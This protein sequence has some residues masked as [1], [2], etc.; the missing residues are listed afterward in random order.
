TRSPPPGEHARTGAGSP[1]GRGHGPSGRECDVMRGLAAHV[2]AMIMRFADAQRGLISHAQ[3]LQCGVDRYAI[4]RLVEQGW[5]RPVTRGVYIVGH[6]GAEP[7]VRETAGI[8]AFAPQAV[9][10]MRSALVLWKICRTGDQLPVH[11][12][13][14]RRRPR[15]RQGFI[16]HEMMGLDPGDV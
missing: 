8:L 9:I 14:R 1:F 13:V 16:V 12:A 15:S 3:M 11:V 4:K 2:V 7:L 10:V 6:A 5:L